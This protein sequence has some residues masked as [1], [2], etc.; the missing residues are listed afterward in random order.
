VRG[1]VPGVLPIVR[2]LE[3]EAR[4]RLAPELYDYY[5]GGAGEERTLAE[6]EAA[7]DRFWLRPRQLTGVVEATT[8]ASVLGRPAGMPVLMA[9]MGQLHHL[10]PDGAGGAARACA[11]AGVPF[12]LSTVAGARPA[13]VRAAAGPGA[14]L[15]LQLYVEQDRGVTR[16][17]LAEARDAGF[18][19][20]TLTVDLPVPGRRERE[21]AHG[22]RAP[23]IGGWGGLRWDDLGWIAEASG[24]PTGVKG[25][26]AAE[27]AAL[28]EA[29]GADH[30]VV[31]NHGGRQLDGA[32]PGPFALR[33]VAA[34][35][36]LPL[37]VDGGVRDGGDVAR[38]L[39]LGA[40]AVLVGRPLGFALAA[41]GAAGVA[42]LLTTLGD[43]LARTLVLLGCARPS[44]VGS[45]HVS[46]DLGRP[47]L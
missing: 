45:G 39:A 19:R 1:T 30:L 10:H 46:P 24:L 8:A 18:E 35:T 43:D 15:W 4:A 47:R 14:A 17:L 25:I 7:W 32:V 42:E 38:A 40:Q 33:E 21:L 13:E 22:D 12:V 31:S 9:P 11:A 5:A 44:D 41:R 20:V 29:A 6:N 28:A 2:I 34:A 37:L 26:V 36:A 23:R 3:E 27:D 16:D